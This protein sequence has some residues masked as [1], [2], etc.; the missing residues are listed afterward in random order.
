[1]TPNT[2]PRVRSVFAILEIRTADGTAASLV[3][4]HAS[5]QDGAMA[6]HSLRE[7]YDQDGNRDVFEIRSRLELSHLRL[8]YNTPGGFNRYHDQFFKL[9]KQIEDCG[10]T[11]SDREKRAYFIGG[12]KDR[13]YASL[14]DSCERDSFNETIVRFSRKATELGKMSGPNRRQAN[15]VTRSIRSSQASSAPNKPREDRSSG[16]NLARLPP[17]VWQQ[18]SPEAR[19]GFIEASRKV[20]RG[21][22]KSAEKQYSKD[23][24]SPR[25]AAKMSRTKFSDKT[26][27]KPTDPRTKP[28]TTKAEGTIETTIQK[29]WSPLRNAKVIKTI[30]IRLNKVPIPLKQKSTETIPNPTGETGKTEQDVKEPEMEARIPKVIRILES[31]GIMPTAK[32]I[33]D[34]EPPSEPED[35]FQLGVPTE[36]VES[37][38]DATDIST[39][40]AVDGENV[41]TMT[42]TPY[43]PMRNRWRNVRVVARVRGDRR[44]EIVGHFIGPNNIPYLDVKVN[45]KL[46]PRRLTDFA[47]RFPTFVI[48]ICVPQPS[49]S[50]GA[51]SLRSPLQH[52]NYEFAR[53]F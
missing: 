21:P 53:D 41:K 38:D 9:V 12:I 1:M 16:T 13:D 33:A 4:R 31:N 23:S 7:Y 5:S 48:G 6:W 34:Q 52:G 29:V 20:K 2:T 15:K 14:K 36:G 46:K 8:E 43:R 42:T 45:G 26:G 51:A 40:A 44:V 10:T 19:R 37:D 50:P 18:M 39:D 25:T 17:A 47:R 22:I 32:E 27:A 35:N 24:A 11:L 28:T 3:T 49:Q 30:K